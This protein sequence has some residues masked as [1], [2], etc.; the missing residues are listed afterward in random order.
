MNSNPNKKL[1]DAHD[2][3][4]RTEKKGRF[5]GTSLQLSGRKNKA[6]KNHHDDRD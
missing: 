2:K 4:S 6:I 1:S 5:G 3:L